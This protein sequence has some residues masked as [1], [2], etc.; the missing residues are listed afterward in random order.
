MFTFQNGSGGPSDEAGGHYNEAFMCKGVFS[1]VQLHEQI[2]NRRSPEK[3]GNESPAKSSAPNAS[4]K[5]NA[6]SSETCVLHDVSGV[7][8]HHAH[9]KNDF[10]LAIAAKHVVEV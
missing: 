5:S 9:Q 4:R 7:L 10:T 1:E 3:R 2:I 6:G 8:L